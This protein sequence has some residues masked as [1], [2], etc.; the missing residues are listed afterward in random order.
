MLIQE[1][2]TVSFKFFKSQISLFLSF[3][4]FY[5]YVISSTK[6]FSLEPD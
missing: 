4:K 1:E 3:E 5:Y 2:I 6:S